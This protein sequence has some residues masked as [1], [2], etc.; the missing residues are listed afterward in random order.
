[1]PKISKEAAD[2]GKGLPQAHCGICQHFT[3]PS[4]CGIVVDPVRPED[5]CKYFARVK[6]TFGSLK[7]EDYD[8][9]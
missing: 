7:T 3:A 6:R 4:H 2:Y 8:A 1:M 5:W 9:R